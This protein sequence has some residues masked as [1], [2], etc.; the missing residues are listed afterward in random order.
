MLRTTILLTLTAAAL[1][2]CGKDDTLTR[3]GGTVVARGADLTVASACDAAPAALALNDAG[4]LRHVPAESLRV[5]QGSTVRAMC[6]LLKDAPK[7]LAVFQFASV[8]CFPCMQAAAKLNADLKAK[9]FGDSVLSVLVLTDPLG[10]LSA[11]DERRLKRDVAPAATWV[12]DDFQDLWKFFSPGAA[13]AELP[14]VTPLLIAMDAAQRGFA[15]DDTAG[16]AAALVARANTLLQLGI[17]AKPA[18]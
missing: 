17:T 5:V 1:S 4:G 8:T 6:D 16:D 9:G 3:A 18:P 7:P 13:G 2:A 10:L 12:Y 14:A 15:S 11:D